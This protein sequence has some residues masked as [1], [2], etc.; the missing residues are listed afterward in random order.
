MNMEQIT[1]PQD[2]YPIYAE[3]VKVNAGIKMSMDKDEQGKEVVQKDGRIELLFFDNQTKRV[4]SRIVLD[5][6]T[7]Q[8]LSKI[9]TSSTTALQKECASPEIP[10]QVREQL[11]QKQQN[12]KDESSLHYIG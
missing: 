7:A 1:I 3:E 11:K 4:I 8:R 10:D 6:S 9:L 2:I 12:P 5:P